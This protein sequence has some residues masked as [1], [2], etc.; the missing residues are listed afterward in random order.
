MAVQRIVSEADNDHVMLIHGP[1]GAG[2]TTVIAASVLSIIE[3]GNREHIIWLTAQSNIA[4]KNITEKL[5]RVK[6]REFKLLVSKD[7]HFDWHEHLYTRLEQCIMRSD[8]FDDD[9][10]T[11]SRPLLNTRVILCT[12]SMLSNP[13]IGVF[14]YL[15]AVQTVIFDE[16]SQIE[17]G[18]YLPMLHRFQLNLQK[19]VFGDDKQ[20]AIGDFISRHVYD[21][22]LKTVYK[23]KSGTACHIERGQEKKSGHSWAKSMMIYTN[24]DFLT[25]GQAADTLVGKLAATVDPEGWLYSSDIDCGNVLL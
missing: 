25:T 19:V 17:V 2:K 9:P 24:R 15:V 18:D 3:Y 8:L 11:I 16:A 20:L 1:P 23:I 10:V 6:F 12:L 22:K 13:D 4:V 5:D 14:S 21:N 7:F